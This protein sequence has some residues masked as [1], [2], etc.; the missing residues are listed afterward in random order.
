MKLVTEDKFTDKQCL[1]DSIRFPRD[2]GRIPRKIKSGFSE[3]TADQWRLWT[4]LFSSLCLHQI[5][6]SE[7]FSCWQQ[8]AIAC[9]LLTNK[10]LTVDSVNLAHDYIVRFCQLS[11]ILYGKAF[12]TLNVH[13]HCH[14]KDCILDYGP[15]HSFWLF[16]FE[17]YNGILGDIHTNHRAITTQLAC[18]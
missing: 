8:F 9:S 15:V 17:R 16:S 1:C 6:P 3:F 4:L 7:H 18:Q 10:V 11:T 5:L 2:V 13:L 14:L 12:A